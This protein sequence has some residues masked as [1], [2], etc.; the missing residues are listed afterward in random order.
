MSEFLER[1]ERLQDNENLRLWR[2]S[3]MGFI[4]RMLES[5]SPSPPSADEINYYIRTFDTDGVPYAVKKQRDAI[6]RGGFDW[7]GPLPKPPTPQTSD[8]P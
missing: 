4:G 2:L 8:R 5:F 7:L 3:R 6:R 1:M